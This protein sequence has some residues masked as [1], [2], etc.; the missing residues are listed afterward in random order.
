MSLGLRC[1]QLNWLNERASATDV[2]AM[3]VELEPLRKQVS[4]MDETSAVQELKAL[5][6]ALKKLINDA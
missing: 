1:F 5:K 6:E 3:E 2:V 4:K